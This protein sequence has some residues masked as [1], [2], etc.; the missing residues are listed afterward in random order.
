MI[1]IEDDDGPRVRS[2]FVIVAVI[3]IDE[4][5]V[6]V[7]VLTRREERLRYGVKR[8]TV[9]R[10]QVIF[11]MVVVI[12]VGGIFFGRTLNASVLMC[13]GFSVTVT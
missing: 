3:V 5:L 9:D 4:S 2:Q 13:F 7:V 10:F 1:S 6:V 8:T 11:A 12:V